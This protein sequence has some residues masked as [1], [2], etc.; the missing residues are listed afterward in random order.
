MVWDF[1]EV[2]F[3]NQFY[4]NQSEKNG[5]SGVQETKTL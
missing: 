1:V 4:Q 3:G 2:V 5:G